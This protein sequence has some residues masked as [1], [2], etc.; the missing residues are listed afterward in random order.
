[1]KR[2]QF[3][4][5]IKYQWLVTDIFV[6][7]VCLL[8]A[9][10]IAELLTTRF[11]GNTDEFHILNI[12]MNKTFF[13]A[14]FTI[15]NFQSKLAIL[16]MIILLFL[17][18]VAV[19]FLLT[20]PFVAVYYGI[21]SAVRRN[22]LAAITFDSIQDIEYFR[23]TWKD[24]SP[25]T[26]SLLMN[27]NIEREKDKIAT[28][29]SLE[30]KK[31]LTLED[32]KIQ[33]KNKQNKMLMDSERKMLDILKT[34]NMNH[35]T[36]REWEK[37]CIDEAVHGGFIKYNKDKKRFLIGIARYIIAFIVCMMAFSYSDKN[38]DKI[39]ND[40]EEKLAPYK[41][42]EDNKNMTLDEEIQLIEEELATPE[43]ASIM[44]LLSIMM[45]CI[46]AM[47]CL[48]ILPIAFLVY[49][50]A[51][52]KSAPRFKRTHKGKLYTEE[53]AGMKNFIHDFSNLNQ[54]DKEQLILW[55]EF[56]IY[57]VVLEENKKI[58]YEISKMK[59]ID[60]SSYEKLSW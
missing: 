13:K 26:I 30:Q 60:I 20:F 42:T 23:D 57:A 12:F 10:K 8:L 25:A 38:F 48:F 53:I 15:N 6:F 52:F 31:Y 46:F 47:I 36:M 28:L 3:R 37:T 35:R 43:I 16:V 54:A 14:F 18:T 19:S 39:S 4:N 7:I 59:Q 2:K 56:L 41:H 33:I 45:A 22:Q 50:I 40:V 11:L 44:L 58:V 32:G 29:L 9:D 5:R 27:L 17:L 24:M 51:Y 55:D 21:R 34:G 49:I 1:M